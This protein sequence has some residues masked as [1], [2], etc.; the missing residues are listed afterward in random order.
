MFY[1]YKTSCIS[2]QQTFAEVNLNNLQESAD[3]KLLVL[4]ARCEGI[5]ANVLRRMSKTVKL[6]IAAAMPLISTEQ[7]PAGIIMGTGNG[8]MEESGK[9]LNQIVEYNEDMLTPTNFVQSTPNTVT[10]QLCM[11][12]K[13]KEYNITHVQRGL[14][15]ETAIVDTAMLLKEYPDKT[16]LLGG[17]DEIAS[18]NHEIDKLDG[19]FRQ[20]TVS[21]RDLYKHQAPGSIAGEGA[22]LFLTGSK[23][24]NAIAELKAMA[25]IHITDA[26]SFKSNLQQFLQQH[27]QDGEEIDLLLSG[28]SGDNRQASFYAISEEAIESNATIARFKHMSGEYPTA[29]AF[30]LWL[31]CMLVSEQVDLPAH[32]IKCQGKSG[33]YKTILIHNTHKGAQHSFMLVRKVGGN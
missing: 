1:I 25:L 13:R 7:P 3:N 5:P 10:S 15:F 31:A 14:S 4:E 24:D 20:E 6:G 30:A 23:A 8:G 27:L 32:A 16:F 11:L 17:V 9:F 26:A 18:Y 19:W 22:A 28:E 33:Q 29:S 21:N 2:P 12:L